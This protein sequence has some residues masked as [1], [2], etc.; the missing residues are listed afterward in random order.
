M[1]LTFLVVLL[2]LILANLN[3]SARLVPIKNPMNGVLDAEL[4]VIVRQASTGVKRL[5]RIEEVFW[6]QAK[7]GDLIDLGEFQLKTTQRD[8]PELIDPVT[9]DTRILL[10]LNHENDA[11]GPWQT[12]YFQ[13]SYFWVQKPEDTP[14]LRASA[15]HATEARR[16]WE[17]ARAISHPAARVA[18]LWPFLDAKVYGVA[19]LEHTKV[20]LI[21]ASPESGEYFA[22]HFTQEN[23]AKVLA[24]AG[25]LGSDALHAKMEFFIVQEMKA[26]EEFV[27]ELGRVPSRDDWSDLPEN[28]KNLSGNI[29][30]GLAGFAR[31]KRPHDLPFIRNAAMWA[32]KYDLEQTAEATMNAFRDMPDQGNL[33]AIHQVLAKFLPERR[34]GVASVD[35]DGERALC[36]HHYPETVPLLVPFL[37][38]NFLKTETE[39]CLIDIVGRDLGQNPQPWMDWYKIQAASHETKP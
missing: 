5:F 30:Y 22:Q 26:Y 38:D 17:E 23:R 27:A 31:F 1:A 18:A 28:A 9:P 16:R 4:V 29:Y 35:V 32:A 7:P 14:T 13:E 20:E 25:D 33:E 3:A 12:T 11:A 24:V 36:E 8:G 39:G 34:P 37:N 15:E 2:I 6:G 10:F 19:F 21:K